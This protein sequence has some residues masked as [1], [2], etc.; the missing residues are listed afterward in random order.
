MKAVME[1][2]RT[3]QIIQTHS[4]DVLATTIKISEDAVASVN[5]TLSTWN[6]GNTAMTETC[7]TAPERESQTFSAVAKNQ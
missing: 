2:I 4:T 7:A 6:V 1:G 3:A 5:S